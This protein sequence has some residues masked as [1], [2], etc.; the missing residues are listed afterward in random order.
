[1]KVHRSDHQLLFDPELEV[2][3][4]KWHQQFHIF[5]FNL[6]YPCLV[7]MWGDPCVRCLE[8]K[9]QSQILKTFGLF[10]H[11][12]LTWFEL[13]STN[14]FAVKLYWWLKR[15]KNEMVHFKKWLWHDWFSSIIGYKNFNT[16]L[17]HCALEFQGFW[18][19]ILN[20]WSV[21]QFREHSP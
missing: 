9:S 17:P 10:V 1:M 16:C 13:R 19:L 14:L 8:F 5:L 7:V 4:W 3:T 6:K 20:H 11:Q 2:E 21:C 15:P 18:C 12:F